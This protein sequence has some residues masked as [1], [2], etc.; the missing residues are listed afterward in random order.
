MIILKERFSE[1]LESFY[2]FQNCIWG[3]LQPR[4]RS[5]IDLL[6]KIIWKYRKHR[7][8]I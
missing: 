5:E 6:K 4:R 8:A 1:S 7:E 3:I 2:H